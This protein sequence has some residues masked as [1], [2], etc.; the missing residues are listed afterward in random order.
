[1]FSL[2]SRLYAGKMLLAHHRILEEAASA[3]LHRWFG[4]LLLTDLDD[5]SSDE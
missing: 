3:S 4:K 5:D 1:M 2:G